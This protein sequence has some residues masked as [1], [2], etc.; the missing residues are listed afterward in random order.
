MAK[1]LRNA[2]MQAD[3]V[4]VLKVSQNKPKD[5]EKEKEKEEEEAAEEAKPAA[6]E[7]KPEKDKKDKGGKP[8]KPLTTKQKAEAAKT[9]TS[10][11]LS[12]PS[13]VQAISRSQHGVTIGDC[14]ASCSLES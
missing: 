14:Y 4:T 6:E 9:T 2:C 12:T 5:R 3:L 13:Q 1:H 10:P 11:A 7:E 8:G